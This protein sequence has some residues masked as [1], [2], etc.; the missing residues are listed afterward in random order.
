MSD[1]REG[2]CLCGAVR[3]EVDLVG[4]ET[5]A[6]HCK[7]CQKQSGAP[8]AIFTLVAKDQFRWLTDAPKGAYSASEKAVRRFCAACGTPL[9]W[10]PA[11][12]GPD[13]N[14][15]TATLDQT[16][17]LSP[18]YELYTRSRMAGIAP[19]TDVPQFEAAH[20]EE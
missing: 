11:D 9:I 12:G 10:D 4:S 1:T 6:C 19:I 18:T 14:F 8:F 7:D 20:S 2:G 13:V 3:Y 17:G 16:S 15:C 5:G